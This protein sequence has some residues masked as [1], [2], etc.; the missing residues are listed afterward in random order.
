MVRDRDRVGVGVGVGSS[1]VIIKEEINL[2]MPLL[3]D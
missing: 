2:L 3:S 1:F